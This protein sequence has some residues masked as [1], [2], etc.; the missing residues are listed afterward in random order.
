VQL[1]ASTASE[2]LPLFLIHPAG[3][4]GLCYLDLVKALSS[5]HGQEVGAIYALD[6]QIVSGERAVPMLNSISE[7]VDA[8]LIAITKTIA[9]KH[10]SGS[11]T[12][13][14]LA[15]WSYGGVVALE[16]AK[17]LS[18]TTH[19]ST[20]TAVDIRINHVSLLDSPLLAANEG[21]Q[22]REE[23]VPWAAAM[24]PAL[25]QRAASHFAHC[26][27]L[28]A[29]YH[30]LGGV[31][32]GQWDG[33]YCPAI[34]DIRPSEAMQHTHQASFF[35]E[36]RQALSQSMASVQGILQTAEVQGSHWTMVTGPERAAIVAE[37]I[38]KH[39]TTTSLY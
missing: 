16:L 17:R 33:E 3:A 39:W 15:G 31:A 21:V 28:L 26:T 9:S 11:T 14:Q 24:D 36:Q 2:K 13:I 37:E 5:F 6:D 38:V 10:S 1:R 19:A 20:G 34:L 27:K 12:I 23:Q 18:S 35:A 30:R 32:K 22:S 7:A 8:A 4:S 25:Q 29:D